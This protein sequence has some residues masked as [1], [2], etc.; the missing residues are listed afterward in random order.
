MNQL[1]GL[2]ILL[3]LPVGLLLCGYWTAALLADSGPAERL[4]FALPAGLAVLLAEIAAINFFHPLAGFWAYVCLAPVG[5][6]LILPRNRASLGHD[7]ISTA[8]NAPRSVLIAGA[9]FFIFLLWPVLTTP[10]GLFY[11]GTSNHDSFFWVAGAEHLKRHT[12]MEMPVV[13]AIQPLTNQT[14][15]LIGWTPAWGRIGAEGLLALASAII[16]LSP[17]KLYLYG[18]ASLA[19]VWSATAFLGLRTFVTESPSRIALAALI[20]LQPIFVFFYGNANLPNLCGALTGTSTLIALERTLRAGPGRRAEFTA[21]GALAALSLHGLICTYPEMVPFILLPCG[22][23]WLR[24][25]FTLGPAAAWRPALLVAAI[26]LAG[27]VLNPATTIRGVNGFL[28]SFHTARADSNWAN[29]F[30]P[31]DVSEYIP[32]L[33]SL[34]ISGSKELG[35]WLGWPLSVLLIAVFGL[36]V[37]RSRDPFGLLAG[38]AGGAALL[39]YTLATD[40]AYGWQKTVQFSG[41]FVALIFPCAALDVLWRWRGGPGWRRRLALTAFGAIALFLAFATVMNCRD[42]YKWSDRKVLSSDWFTLRDRSRTQLNQAPIL[43]E[44]GSFRMAFFHSM[45]AAYFLSDSHIYYGARGVESGGY[46]RSNVVS[47]ATVEI[48]KPAAILV[49]RLWAD[50]F[51]ANSPRFLEG[52]E[53]AL[54]QKSNRVLQASG[55]YPLNGP[56]D[57]GTGV[58]RWEILPHSASQL[59]FVVK[60]RNKSGWPAGEWRVRRKVAG[61]PDYESSVSGASPWLLR[62][63]LEANKLNQIEVALTGKEGIPDQ[64][65]FL[66]RNLRIESNP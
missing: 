31:L 28:A 19:L 62:I 60:P 7:L 39:V 4:A 30:N 41:I 21:W 8:R 29:L 1:E 57:S 49:G 38:L 59:A 66:L 50:T 5:L 36:V 24:P 32:G 64:L 25:W 42:I 46:L 13:S 23:L 15:A 58:M 27:L 2:L 12:Y 47:E 14:G 44:A 63:P 53:Y 35:G 45:W 3:G 16:G 56:P 40:F 10:S 34:S 52:H 11:D 65:S 48:P 9:L 22:L 6:T 33:V 18:T 17:L 20:S 37:W 54:L 55:V 51:D 43:V 61:L 26:M